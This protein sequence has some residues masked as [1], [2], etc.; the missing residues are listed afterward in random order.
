MFKIALEAQGESRH[1]MIEALKDALSAVEAG[2]DEAEGYRL[3]EYS[4]QITEEE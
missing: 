2:E 4:F 1:A 3:A